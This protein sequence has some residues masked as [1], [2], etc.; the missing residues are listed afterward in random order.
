MNKEL[1]KKYKNEFEHWINGGNVQAFYKKD[2]EPKWITDEECIEYEGYDNFT[3]ILQNSLEPEDVLIIIDD[4]YIKF[5]GA[6]ANDKIVEYLD[7]RDEWRDLKENCVLIEAIP[8]KDLRIKPEHKFKV[9]DWVIHNGVHKQVTKAV[10]G[11]IDSLDNQVA[12]I[13]KEESLELWEPKEEEYF[14]Y[15][16]DLVKFDEIKT[17]CGTLL[18]SVRGCSYHTTE[19]NYKEYCEPFIGQLPTSIKDWL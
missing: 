7:F 18:N 12:V 19:A 1:I 4:E 11:Y 16:N 17:N 14:W 5:R 10:D 8:L 9:G 15:K 2:D 3:H 13:M 6:L